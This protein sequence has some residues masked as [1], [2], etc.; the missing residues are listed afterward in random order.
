M[1][2]QPS[3]NNMDFLGAEE[4]WDE[5]GEAAEVAAANP[6]EAEAAIRQAEAATYTLQEPRKESE[7]DN[8][9]TI[10]EKATFGVAALFSTSIL[11][12][13]I[14]LTVIGIIFSPVTDTLVFG[15][16]MVA[17]GLTTYYIW[18][19]GRRRAH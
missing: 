18:R 12:I 5:E 15:L 16:L 3:E 6:Q 8:R 10:T 17:S 9:L 2:W 14:A 4:E 19:G 11:V 7:M 13:C 1:Q